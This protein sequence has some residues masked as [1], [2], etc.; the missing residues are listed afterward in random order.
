MSIRGFRESKCGEGDVEMVWLIIYLRVERWRE[1]FFWSW[2]VVKL[3]CEEDVWEENEK[4]EMK[5]VLGM[6]FS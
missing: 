2:I 3:G 5:K 4:R 1:V 6:I